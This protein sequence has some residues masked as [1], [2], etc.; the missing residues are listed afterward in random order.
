MIGTAKSSLL[1]G[2]RPSS[3]AK[4]EVFVSR[5]APETTVDSVTTFVSDTIKLSV[6]CHKLETRYDSYFSFKL[7]TDSKNLLSLLDP[8]VWPENVLVR[9]FYNKRHDN[10]MVGL[11]PFY[12]K[13]K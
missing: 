1:I 6:E 2:V 3:H 4:A 8:S 9:K 10:A 7:V 5:L 11:R 12:S 13:R